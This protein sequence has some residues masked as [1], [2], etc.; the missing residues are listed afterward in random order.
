MIFYNDRDLPR[1]IASFA[2]QSTSIDCTPKSNFEGYFVM[3]AKDL[4]TLGRKLEALSTETPT[5]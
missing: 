3:Q 1:A 4:W 2:A 5:S